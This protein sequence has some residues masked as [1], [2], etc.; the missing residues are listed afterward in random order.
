MLPYIG[1]F[2]RGKIFMN[3]ANGTP[4]V[5]IFP[6]KYLGW[7]CSNISN[8]PIGK[9]SLYFQIH[10]DHYHRYHLLL[11]FA[12]NNMVKPLIKEEIQAV[13]F[14]KFSDFYTIS[15]LFIL[16]IARSYSSTANI[17]QEESMR[18]FHQTRKLFS[19]EKSHRVWHADNYL[20]PVKDWP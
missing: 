3:F 19:L 2:W 13:G 4:P 1:Y 18:S 10:R 20:S 15:K 14:T 12:I 5:K 9:L 17:H 11:E 7:L 16:E 6:V 8:L